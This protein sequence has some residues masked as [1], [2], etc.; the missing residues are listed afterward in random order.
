MKG[1][2]KWIIATFQISDKMSRLESSHRELLE[3]WEQNQEEFEENLD[4]QIFQRD[5]EQAETWITMRETLLGTE[6]LGV[7]GECDG[8]VMCVSSFSMSVGE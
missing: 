1:L 5:A 2:F 8:I 4:V 6:E 7:R 3:M